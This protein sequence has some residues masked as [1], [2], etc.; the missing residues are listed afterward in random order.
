MKNS[1]SEYKVG[2][3]GFGFIGKVHA[4]G[5]LNFPL[6]YDPLNFNA[7]ITHICTSRMG[8]AEKGCQQI[9]AQVATTDYRDITENPD[10]DIVHICSPNNLHLDALLSAMKHNKHIYCDKPLVANADE[11]EQ[12]EAAL[13]DYKSTAQ[14]TFQLRFYPAVIRAKQLIDEGFLGQILEFRSCF[15]HA[16]SV[17]PQAPLKWKLSAEAG[18]GIIADLGSHLFDLIHYLIGNYAEIMAETQIAYPERPATDNPEKMIPVEV[19]DNVIMLAKMQ[20]GA[21]GT[22]QATKL[23][24]G[25][26]DEIRFEIHGTKGAIRFNGTEPHYLEIFDQTTQAA[27]IGGVAGWTKVATGQKY[28][29]PAGF[30]GG[31][32]QI[33][34]IRHHMACLYNFMESVVACTP[35]NPGLEQGIYIQKMMD[36]VEQS[37]QTKTWVIIND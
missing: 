32:L 7:K 15:L 22:I 35:G 33:G 34:W 29:E 5:Y 23:A 10:I 36:K 21:L 1:I 24:T 8:T 9:G 2:I 31:K 4:Y 12:I 37:A 27:P 3:I 17:D 18:G 28:P 25:T 20:N 11:A 30:P 13:A 6:F 26:E 19:A 16:G 14:M